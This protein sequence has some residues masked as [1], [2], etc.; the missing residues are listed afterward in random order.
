MFHPLTKGNI[1][2][3]VEIQL[4]QL[5]K[6]LKEKNILLS[7]TNEAFDWIATAGYDPFFG[8]RPVK[9]VIQKQVMNELSKTLLAGSIE[10]D[11][12]IVMDVFDGKVVF[13]KP[14]RKEE[15]MTA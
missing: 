12:T 1:R 2:Q 15:E 4:N 7:I 10:P 14:I 3:I 6:L 11:S 5:K 9:R 8:A 13:R